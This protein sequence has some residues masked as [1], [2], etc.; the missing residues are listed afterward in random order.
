[1]GARLPRFSCFVMCFCFVAIVS[2]G[3]Q[4]SPRPLIT[5]P[6]VESELITLKGNTHPLAQP[7]SDIGAAPP[8]LPMNRMLLVLKR[9]PEQ[10]HSLRTLLDNQQDKAS[11]HYHKW[12]TPDQFGTAFGPADQD[13]Q[14]V[15]GWLQTHGFQV[16]RVSH[17]RTVV[18]FSGTEGQVEE[19]LH[20][21]IHKYAVNGEEHWANASDPQIPAALVPAVAGVWSLHDFQ[22]RPS[23]RVSDYRIPIP[24]PGASPML[25]S[26][27]QHALMPGDYATIYNISPLYSVGVT[28]QGATIAVVAR[29]NFYTPDL[30]DFHNLAGTP[31]ANLNFVNDGPAPGI[32][33]QNEEAEAVLDVSWSSAIAPQ[34]QIDFVVSAST[35]TTDGVDL[36]ELYIIDNNLSDVMTESFGSCE[37]L[38]TQAEAQAI[39]SLSEQGA[40]EG[41]TYMVSSGDSGAEGCDSPSQF[42]ANGDAASVNILASSAFTVAIGGT[43]FN[44]G[45]NSGNYWNTS[46]NPN[47]LA[48]AKSYIPENVWNESCPTC[49]LWAGGGGASAFFAKPNWQFGLRGI[50]NDQARDLPDVSLTAAGHD[51]YLLCFEGSCERGFLVGIAGTSA[52]SPSFAGIMAL[53]VQQY[54]RQGQGNYVLYRLA[55]TE[56]LSQC[57]GSTTAFLPASTCV[58]NDV[59]TGN[60]AVPGEAGYGTASAKYQAGVGYDLTTGLGSVNAANLVN[61]WNT[62][63]F[64]ATTTTLAPNSITATH[65]NPVT[66]DIT[67]SPSSGT[68]VPT[69]DV[70]LLAGSSSSPTFAVL[71]NGSVSSQVTD[72]PGGSYNLTARYGGDLDFAPSQSNSIQVSIAAED[73][74]TTT[75][76]LTADPTGNPIPFS[77]GPLGGF[78]YP[79][80]DV[81]AKSGKGIPTG[82][83]DFTDNGAPLTYQSSYYLNSAGALAFPYYWFTVGQHTLLSSYIGDSSFHPST[84]APLTFTITRATSTTAVA[85]SLSA[86]AQGGSVNLTANVTSPAFAGQSFG[87]YPG[88][89]VSFFS[90]N[91][92][93]GSGQPNPYQITNSGVVAIATFSTSSLPAGQNT[94]TAQYSGDSNYS[95]SSATPI[96]VSVDA[97]FAVAPASS[98]VTISSPGGSIT[99]S[100]TIT[101]QTGYNGTINFSANSC[102]GLP[103]LS[104]CSFSPATV[105]GS[106]STIVTIRTT[107]PTS[108]AVRRSGWAGIGFMFAGVLLLNTKRRRFSSILAISVLLVGLS[109]ASVGCGGGGSS[110]GTGRPG[111]TP[112]TYNVVVTASTADGVDSHTT[113]F[114]VIIQ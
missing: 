35:N 27:G 92:Q 48:S 8:D 3:Q 26:Q 22:K 6:V 15:T 29:S 107:A 102:S 13:V 10:E 64:N 14:I 23:V 113:G 71:S 45:G 25:T 98:S 77:S 67:V 32:V 112:G 33:N 93:L 82:G 114:T 2:F 85:A 5:Q 42:S 81:A 101:G 44:E 61:K 58:F 84:S 16:N 95:G 28:G 24:Q 76:I 111:T 47:T 51:P 69:G 9:S 39:S 30:Y 59:T 53:V 89:T 40:A 49:G 31:G 65:G 54:G 94:V 97:D 68:G 87:P 104:S 80:A 41:I 43:E 46:N 103:A 1:M 18:E 86:I 88:G 57:N 75:S 37:R 73:S 70:A 79:R 7:Q 4:V 21:S 52:A 72:L 12:L 50:P 83:L 34:A 74:V 91:T 17:G 60:N 38:A 110:G 99:N 90:N 109:L 66:L 55:A 62:I 78:V 63:K 56:T 11:M 19:A 108:A 106:G 20:T 36:S 100:L 96:T 105:T